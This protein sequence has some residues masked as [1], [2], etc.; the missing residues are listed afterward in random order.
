MEKKL[1]KDAI[2]NKKTSEKSIDY[3]KGYTWEY[4]C[5]QLRNILISDSYYLLRL[6]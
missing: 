5:N 2:T 3:F 6:L 4:A 1:L